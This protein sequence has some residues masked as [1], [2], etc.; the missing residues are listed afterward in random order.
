MQTIFTLQETIDLIN[1][2][3]ALMIAGDEKL[4]D[5]LPKGNWIGGTT[6]YFIGDN[7]GEVSKSKLFVTVKTDDIEAIT[8]NEYSS[9]NINEFP[10][11]GYSNGATLIILPAF[12]DIHQNYAKN[13]MEIE[14]VFDRPVAGWVSGVHLDELNEKTPKVINGK[15][16]EL[17]GDKA[18]IAQL[19]LKEDVT[20][21]MDIVNLFKQDEG[22]IITFGK[23]GFSGDVA[24]VNG[25]KVIFSDY[26][27]ENNIDPKL[28]LVADFN[29]AM[30]NVSF[31]EVN[32]E[33]GF[34]NFYA[35]VFEG[36]EYRIAAPVTN[37]VAEF[38][39]EVE[40]IEAT[41]FTSV[42][43][44]L[45]F[46]FAELEGQKTGEIKGPITFG[47]IAYLLLNQTMVHVSAE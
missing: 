29:G 27:T 26:L 5:Q 9:A 4:L 32:N 38:N 30:I 7:G 15:T 8:I 36:V 25:K 46:L 39:K 21:S 3:K 2:D 11:T 14:G 10:A 24:F 6:A 13:V 45:N 28:P 22:D 17:L 23:T 40:N 43:C 19:K 47:E 18:I 35:P 42:N 1:Q 16:G 37:Y 31:Q 34:V 20:A 41:P 33:K 44:I 12:S